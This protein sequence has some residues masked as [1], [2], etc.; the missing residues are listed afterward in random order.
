[1]QVAWYRVRGRRLLLKRFRD[2][3][4]A[5]AIQRAWRKHRNWKL[6]EGRWVDRHSGRQAT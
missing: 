1:M 2:R 5:M 6:L 3:K 4:A